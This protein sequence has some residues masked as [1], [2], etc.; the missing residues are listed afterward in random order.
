MNDYKKYSIEDYLND[1][2]FI[3]SVL[4]PTQETK[5]YWDALIDAGALDIYTYTDAVL[6][7][8]GWKNSAPA[9]GREDLEA[10]WRRIEASAAASETLPATASSR[11]DFPFWKG[12]RTALEA[13]AAALSLFLLLPQQESR[14]PKEIRVDPGFVLVTQAQESDNV[15]IVSDRQEIELE[16]SKPD[17]N[18]NPQGQLKVDGN[19]RETKQDTVP[20]IE[21]PA[22]PETELNRIIVPYGKMASLTLSD[23]STLKINAGTTVRYPKTFNGDTRTIEVDGEIFA[24]VARDGRPFVVRSKD[25][26]VRVTGT[27]FNLSSYSTDD[28]SQVV[29]V[30][31]GVTVLLEGSEVALTPSQAFEKRPDGTSVLLV[32]TD[33]YTSWTQGVYKFENEPLENVLIRLARFYN[34]SLVLPESKSGVICYG[35]LELRDDLSTL[36]T[37]LMQIASFN[38]V[39]RDGAHVIQWGNKKK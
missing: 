8:T 34:V 6:I 35:S 32:D 33:L 37:G 19:V 36:L 4:S 10:T 39:I 9:A 7:L 24:D 18:Y 14:T 29:L 25:F 27:Q 30:K 16:G 21:M 12:V 28:Y 22:L 20:Q 26:D 11:K 23:G 17:V 38:F 5:R 2:M 31:G 13:A 1:E 3:R 15:V